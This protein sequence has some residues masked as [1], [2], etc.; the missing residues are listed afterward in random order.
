MLKQ[1]IIEGSRQYL[2]PLNPRYPII[3][4]TEQFKVCGVVVEKFKIYT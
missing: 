4:L 2:K 1:L 3:A